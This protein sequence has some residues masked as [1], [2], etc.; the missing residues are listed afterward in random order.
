[1]RPYDIITETELQQ[2]KNGVIEWMEE[3]G[4]GYD[5]CD[6]VSIESILR[7]WNEAKSE[8][9][10]KLLG[11]ELIISKPFIYKKAIEEI[12]KVKVLSVNTINVLPK[13]KRVGQHVGYKPAYKKAICKLADGDKIDAFEI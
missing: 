9:L 2:F 3:Y 4:P 10:F 11:N 7:P 13:R 5:K 6:P 8:Y 12:F 1:M